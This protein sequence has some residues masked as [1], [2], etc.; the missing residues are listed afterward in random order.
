SLRLSDTDDPFDTEIDDSDMEVE[1]PKRPNQPGAYR[2]RP[3]VGQIIV[4]VIQV[5]VFSAIFLA[6]F[7]AVGFGAVFGGQKVGL[8]PTRAPG[9]SGPLIALLPTAGPAQPQNNGDS[10]TAAPQ[11]APTAAPV[12]TTDASC[13]SASDWWNSQQVQSNYQYFAGTAINDARGSDKIPALLEAMRIKRNFV[14]SFQLNG[15]PLD[16]CL[17]DAKA[18]LIK[19]FDATIEAARAIGAKDDAALTTQ[20]ANASQAFQDMALALRKYGVVATLVTPAA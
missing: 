9:G 12:A 14:D 2:P 17:T 20:Q 11:N 10:P 5:I 7:L 8:V 15:K 13:A 4:G 3:T 1:T 18:A 16:V 19:G 6:I